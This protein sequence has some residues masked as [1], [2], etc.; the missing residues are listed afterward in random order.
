MPQKQHWTIFW[1]DGTHRF[2]G[3]SSTVY[4]QHAKGLS[5]SLT[6]PFCV[7]PTNWAHAVV[8]DR[9]WAFTLDMMELCK[10][11]MII[12]K[13]VL[14]IILFLFMQLQAHT[15]SFTQVYFWL[16]SILHRIFC[17]TILI[18]SFMVPSLTLF[19]I[20]T[21]KNLKHVTISISMVLMPSMFMVVLKLYKKATKSSS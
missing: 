7:Y 11:F 14:N 4:L 3:Q 8:L 17:N 20:S 1:M 15:P 16:Y 18:A 19:F 10:D 13:K 5:S 6:L 21:H 2:C 9:Q 12:K